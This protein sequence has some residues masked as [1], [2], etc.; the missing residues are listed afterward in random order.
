MRTRARLS[1]TAKGALIYIA[2]VVTVIAVHSVVLHLDRIT[3]DEARTQA[4]NQHSA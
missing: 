1:A 4:S 2:A 3:E